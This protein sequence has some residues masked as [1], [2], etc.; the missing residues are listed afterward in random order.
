MTGRRGTSRS[1]DRF[2]F[3]GF[4]NHCGQH[5]THENKG[6]SLVQRKKIEVLV[7]QLC[8]TLCDFMDCGL[9]GFSVHGI[10]QARILRWVSI[11]FSRDPG[12]R[13]RTQ[14]SC[15]AGRFFTIQGTRKG[16]TRDAMTNLDRVLKSKDITLLTKV[17]VA[18]EWFFQESCADVRV[19]SQ[20]RLSAKELMLL[21]FGA[22]GDSWE[23][24]GQQRDQTS[25]F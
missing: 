18:K 7:A 21:N 14:V 9:P 12:P 2:A 24:L 5:C 13:D 10:F 22:G 6:R 23:S 4:R 15:I 19:G 11:S 3:L 17:R 25:P 1:S 16:L 20:R 8:L